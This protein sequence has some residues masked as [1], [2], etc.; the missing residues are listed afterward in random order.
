M[1]SILLKSSAEGENDA[2]NDSV[3]VECCL[4]ENA[5]FVKDKLELGLKF[6]FLLPLLLKPT[7]HFYNT[8][9]LQ[10]QFWLARST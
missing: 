10:S 4:R 1:L 6:P 8:F 5:S 2:K 9:V 7:I 3:C